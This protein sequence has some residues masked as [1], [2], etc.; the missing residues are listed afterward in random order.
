MTIKISYLKVLFHVWKREKN[1][2][3]RK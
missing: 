1:V 2:L 3:K